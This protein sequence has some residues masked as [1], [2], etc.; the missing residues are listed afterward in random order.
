MLL[1]WWQILEIGIRIVSVRE[2]NKSLHVITTNNS[3]SSTN[4]LTMRD[5][6]IRLKANLPLNLLNLVNFPDHYGGT[7]EFLTAVLN[8]TA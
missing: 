3:L 8:G 1:Q 2:Q 5:G 6:M 4:I 7:C